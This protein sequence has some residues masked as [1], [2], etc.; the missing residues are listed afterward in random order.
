MIIFIFIAATFLLLAFA[1]VA[2]GE[3]DGFLQQPSAQTVIFPYYNVL[4]DAL[5]EM[6]TLLPASFHTDHQVLNYGT[7][8]KNG[9]PVYIYQ[10]MFLGDRISERKLEDLR[11]QLNALIMSNREKRLIQL[12]S[13]HPYYTTADA[14]RLL[15]VWYYGFYVMTVSKSGNYIFF[16]MCVLDTVEAQNFVKMQLSFF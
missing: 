10:I 12:Y 16:E 11:I 6:I 14:A 8:T 7:F 3:K 13:V 15:P 4:R 9:F 5:E 2:I 1:Y